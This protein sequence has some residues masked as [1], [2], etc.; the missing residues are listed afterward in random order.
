MKKQE[1]IEGKEIRI[2]KILVPLDFSKYS[3]TTMNFAISLSRL[4]GAS[5]LALHVFEKPV[6]PDAIWMSK[7]VIDIYKNYYKQAEK[8]A[9]EELNKFIQQFDT[10]GIDLKTKVLSGIPHI[11]ITNIAQKEK[12]NLIV[13]GSKGLNVLQR[14]L[15][16]STADRV[17]R[18]AKCNVLVLKR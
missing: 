18:R 4:T 16:G 2:K 1:K 17:V 9:K 13:L 3:V 8:K 14:I 7:Q 11:Q 5:I 15:I 12:I 6:I 10:R